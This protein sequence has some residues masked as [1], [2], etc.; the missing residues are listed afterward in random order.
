MQYN[1]KYNPKPF[2]FLRLKRLKG[3]QINIFFTELVKSLRLNLSSRE[4]FES[5]QAIF[6]LMI[7][8]PAISASHL[9]SV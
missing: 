3:N 8:P 1:L 2:H 9:L 5:L 7:F 4:L 6:P